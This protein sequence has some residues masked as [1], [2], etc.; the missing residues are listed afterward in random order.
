MY[1]RTNKSEALQQFQNFHVL[2]ERQAEKNLK[3]IRSDRGGEFS[4]A[5]FRKYC[6]IWGMKHEYTGPY[7]LQQNGV[8]ESKNRT[9]VEMARCLLK[10]GGLPIRFWGEAVSTAVY[11]INRSP[12]HALQ[13]KTP[14]EVWHG[15]IPSVKH[16][17]VFGCLAFALIPAHKLHKLDEKS[18]RCIFVG[19]SGESKAYRLYN[20][21]FCRNI[22]SRDVIFYENS[23]WNWETTRD[24]EPVIIAEEEAE[25]A[26]EVT[27]I[28]SNYERHSGGAGGGTR[29]GGS[30][31]LGEASCT[32]VAPTDGSPP[33]RTRLLTDVYNSCT[34]ALHIA[35]PINFSE[36]VKCKH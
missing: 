4:S 28:S 25:G 32:G 35:D 19:Y 17:R 10:S 34:F 7:T 5:A 21:I 1:L 8:V 20:P 15:V 3:V 22:I 36:A 13:N 16:L 31:V 23:W 11:I 6:E 24:E 12:T 9:V 30:R 2:V 26:P 27:R 29:P 14:F 33:I 18:E